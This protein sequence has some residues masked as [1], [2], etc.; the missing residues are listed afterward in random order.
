MK[1]VVAGLRDGPQVSLRRAVDGPE[2]SPFTRNQDWPLIIN[3]P[4]QE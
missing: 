3:R 2:Y 4:R 1:F